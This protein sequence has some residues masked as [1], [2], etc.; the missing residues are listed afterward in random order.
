MAI[1]SS[2]NPPGDQAITGKNDLQVH[3]YTRLKFL[4]FKVWQLALLFLLVIGLALVLFPRRKMLI[5]YYKDRGMLDEAMSILTDAQSKSP[6]DPELLFM[7]ADLYLADSDPD[8]AITALEQYISKTESRKGLFK[9][10]TLYEDVR[11]PKKAMNLWEK[12]ANVH[13]EDLDTWEKLITYYAYYGL[14]DKQLGAMIHYIQ[15]ENKTTATR[16]RKKPEPSQGIVNNP[17]LLAMKQEITR[18]IAIHNATQ[19]SDPYR[20]ELIRSLFNIRMNLMRSMKPGQSDASPDPDR[21][22]FR[23]MEQF[24]RTGLIDDGIRLAKSLDGKWNQGIG[25]RLTFIK[26]LRWNRLDRQALGLLTQIYDANKENTNLLKDIV[27]IARENNDLQTAIPIYTQLVQKD[28][29]NIEKQEQLAEL[30]FEAGNIA[31]AYS[32]YK[33]IANKQRNDIQ[34]IQKLFQLASYSDRKDVIKDAATVG[35]ELRPDDPAIQK[36]AAEMLLGIG[37]QKEAIKSYR[38]YL[39]LNPKDQKA[40]ILLAELYTWTDQPKKAYSIYKQMA[41]KSKGNKAS[42]AKMIEIAASTGSSD[43][44]Q[45]SVSVA[46]RL[47]PQDKAFKHKSAELLLAAGKEKEAIN[48]YKQYLIMNPDDEAAKRQLIQLY[49]WTDQQDKTVDLLIQLS[50][51]DADNFEKALTAGKTLVEMGNIEDGVT[52]LKRASK[53]KPDNIELRKQLVSYYGWLGRDDSAVQ[54]LEFLHSVGKLPEEHRIRLSQTYLDR[55]KGNKALKLLKPFESRTP[56]PKDE[57]L[58]LTSAYELLGQLDAVAM[59]Y[60]QLAK[61]NSDDP[62]LLAD[63][64]NRALWMQ[65]TH[66]ALEFYR[67][68]LKKDPKQLQALKGSAQIYAWNNDPE[69]AIERFEDYNRLNPDDYEVRYQLGELY[70]FNDRRGDAFKEYRKALSLMKQTKDRN[71]DQYSQ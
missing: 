22:L 11:N 28:P 14:M 64:G 3:G 55:K 16:G 7:S 30:Y 42:V 57:G 19:K 52:Y 39:R 12:I 24:A 33:E 62:N 37:A 21:A 60:R 59:I 18:H 25:I 2:S 5:D 6:D 67:L 31:K 44:I 51:K 63:L 10:A 54:E 70:F 29:D 17:I 69:R 40:Q 71:T 56:L 43:I 50:D 41:V 9:L 49:Q 4:N 47:R 68:A 23:F 8:K 15:N 65:K 34:Y 45:E 46:S 36:Q 32:L 48:A 1:G 26:I 61:E 66:M 13:P 27:K 20:D 58:M 35:T 53:I 38:N